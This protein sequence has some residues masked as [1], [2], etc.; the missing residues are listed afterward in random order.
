[1]QASDFLLA[2]L[3]WGVANLFVLGLTTLAWQR[4]RVGSRSVDPLVF[5]FLYLFL[6]TLLVMLFG[7]AGWL[8]RTPLVVVSLVGCV[9]MGWA[10]RSGR[11]FD[12]SQ[13]RAG[14]I[15]LGSALRELGGFQRKGPGLFLT[16][17]LLVSL[18]FAQFARLAV[19]VWYLPP[20]VWDTLSYHLPNVAEWVQNHRLVIF[21]TPVD[22]TFWPANFELFETWFVL[23]PHHDYLVDAAGIPFYL[24]A[25]AGVYSIARTL[26]LSR[27]FAL[28]AAL[29]YVYTPAVAIHA[30]TG[31]NDLAI[32]AVY[33]FMAALILDGGRR[34]TH[35]ERRSLLLW[36][37]LCLA[38]GTKVTIV[39]IV[40][41]L[42]LLALWAWRG[43]REEGQPICSADE[44]PS[45]TLLVS[46]VGGAGLVVAG[47]WFT[48]N[49]LVFGNPFHPTD[50]HLFGHLIFGT[51]EGQGQQ[52]TISFT[53]LAQNLEALLR[54]KIF[55]SAGPY[56]HSLTDMTGW[57]W[58]G[59]CCGLPALAY[60]LIARA[61]VRWLA[62]GFL[63]SLVGL[64]A[65]VS[66]DPWNMR[67]A[68]WFPALLALSFVLAVSRLRIRAIRRSFYL[69]ATTCLALNF[70]GTLD[71]GFLPPRAWKLMAGLPL[72]ERSAAALGPYF[73]SRYMRA[74][75]AIPREEV[76][77]YNVNYNGWI[78]PLYDADLSRRIL[79]VPIHHDTDVA[80]AMLQRDL[81]YL[82]VSLPPPVARFRIAAAVA[83]GGLKQI[84][85]NLYVRQD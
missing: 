68:L 76:I 41:G 69:L 60:G 53:S 78:Y 80:E 25:G 63:V 55:D 46:L 74:L 77:G 40:P 5:G 10:W 33:L 8:H 39:F 32:A 84:G 34:R 47:Y 19:R 20:Y 66:P 83:T 72:A 12:T 42:L 71:I 35:P 22:R 57:G 16:D 75:E 48:R 51:G 7:L 43:S 30:T 64:L 81:R 36:L 6:T 45:R 3:E 26:G 44:S 73:G 70:I 65:C 4:L 27:R 13:V 11:L 54:E 38:I 61:P 1:M 31:K 23:F 56:H 79:F 28:V 29:L 9:A 17:L 49:S 82:F 14:L 2:L 52:G 62:G 58:F 59:F 15:R 85:E 50:F 67:F 18:V 21:D 37:A 24:L